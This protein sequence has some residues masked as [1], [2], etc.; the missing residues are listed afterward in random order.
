[1]NRLYFSIPLLLSLCHSAW[2]LDVGAI[3]SFMHS[4]SAIL[5]KEIKNTTDNGRLVN[6]KVERI[7]NPSESGTVIPMETKDEMLL[8]PASLMMPANASDVIRFYYKGP[9]DNKERFY[10]I[11]WL[12]QALSDAGQNTAKRNAVATTS[13]RIGTI[14]VVTPR[15]AQFS[16]QFANGTLTNTG[17]ATFKM[18]A[19]GACKDKK[20]GSS[21][22][23][24]YFVMPGR[25]RTLAKVDINDKKSHVA[26]WYG[27]QFIQVK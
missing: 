19:Y 2:A 11:T 6:I 4:D 26:L 16:H 14:L 21:C 13:A 22:K 8:S 18:V 3:S 1:M 25:E 17:N 7:S 9:E 20:N 5:S 15:K 10:R 12:D 27:E 23:E 24:N